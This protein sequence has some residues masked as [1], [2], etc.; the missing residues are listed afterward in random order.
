VFIRAQRPVKFG[1]SP[2][3]YRPLHRSTASA[4]SA[5]SGEQMSIDERPDTTPPPYLP[6]SGADR[7]PADGGAS[8]ATADELARAAAEV[9]AMIEHHR[10]ELRAAMDELTALQRTVRAEIRDAIHELD[11]IAGGIT[12]D[13]PGPP[14]PGTD[15]APRRRGRFR[16]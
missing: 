1:F 15:R 3:L 13:A 9:V 11:R 6:P 5:G 10:G 7:G 4:R 12:D 16:R 2:A 14:A 8:A